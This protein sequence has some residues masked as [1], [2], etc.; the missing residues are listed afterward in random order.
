LTTEAKHFVGEIS[1]ADLCELERFS[2]FFETIEA[3]RAAANGTAALVNSL[4][5]INRDWGVSKLI[6]LIS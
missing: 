5:L 6:S 1:R 4:E 3:C 2:S